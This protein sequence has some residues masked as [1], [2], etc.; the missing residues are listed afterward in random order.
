MTRSRNVTFGVGMILA[1]A[2]A[3]EGPLLP[4]S[5]ELRVQEAMEASMNR[6]VAD[7]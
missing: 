6:E 3:C 2:P 5:G 1:L 7:S 4:C